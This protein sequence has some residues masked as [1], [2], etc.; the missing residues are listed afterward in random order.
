MR[1]IALTADARRHLERVTE[2]LEAGAPHRGAVAGFDL[3]WFIA[4]PPDNTCGTVCCVA[5]ALVQFHRED[6]GDPPLTPAQYDADDAYRDARQLMDLTRDEARELFCLDVSMWVLDHVFPTEAASVLR[7]LLT[8]GVLDWAPVL[9][10]A[11]ERC[12]GR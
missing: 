9:D 8:D 2:W 1:T 7:R 6:V 10:L 4:S 3:S 5:G 12:Y 11:E